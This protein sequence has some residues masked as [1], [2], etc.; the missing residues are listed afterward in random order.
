MWI[1]IGSLYSHSTNHLAFATPSPIPL[2]VKAVL[3]LC[4]LIF[5][6]HE[7]NYSW[8]CMSVGCESRDSSNCRQKI[9]RKM[10][11]WTLHGCFPSWYYSL[12][13][14]YINCVHSIHTVLC[15]ISKQEV[16]DWRVVSRALQILCYFNDLLLRADVFLYIHTHTQLS[17]YNNVTC[18]YVFSVDHL[19]LDKHLAS[20]FLGKA[21]FPTPVFPELCV[22]PCVGLRSP[23]LFLNSLSWSLVLSLSAHV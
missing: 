3:L 21:M 5:L 15:I 12:R 7:S 18:R 23:G 8:L 14:Y 22:V 20:S 6:W 17:P 9:F 10:L 19:T 13:L 1:L 4:F 2:S 16:I 11:T